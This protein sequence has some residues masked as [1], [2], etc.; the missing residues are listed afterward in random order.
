MTLA[1]CWMTA[2]RPLKLTCSRNHVYA[3]RLVAKRRA[4]CSWDLIRRSTSL[5]RGVMRCQ[6]VRSGIESKDIGKV[7]G[8]L[9]NARPVFPLRAFNLRFGT[10]RRH[11]DTSYHHHSCSRTVSWP[12]TWQHIL[13]NVLDALNF[14]VLVGH[15]E[16]G[17]DDWLPTAAA[18]TPKAESAN[19]TR[20]LD[21]IAA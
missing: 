8:K 6:T 19:K 10:L 21:I 20:R 17:C 7:P 3:S 4:Q 12:S 9:V 2:C 15:N 14:L 13:H 18:A 16:P 1:L 5:V 11:T